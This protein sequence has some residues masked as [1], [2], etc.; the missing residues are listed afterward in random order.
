MS[1]DA[2]DVDYVREVV[3]E[4]S[5]IVLDATKAYLVES[6]LGP[7]ARQVGAR[8]LTDLVAMLRSDRTGRLR[9]L[10]VDAMTTNETTF[11]RDVGLWSAL[12]HRILPELIA[13]RAPERRLTVWSAACSSGQEPYSLAMLLLDRFPHVVAGFEVRIVATDLSAEMLGRAAAGRF[14]QLEVNRGLP[15]PLL[16]KHFVRD[17]AHWQISERVRS[18]VEFRALN[19]IGPWPLLPPVDL[20]FLRN[21]LIYFDQPTKRAI[22]GQCRRLLRPD[23]HLVLGTAETTLAI[24]DSYHRSVTDGAT[25]YRPF[26]HAS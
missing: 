11:F 20:L 10:V 5:A 25:T 22:L 9:E 2:T 1:L 19:L 4:R 16:V 26:A 14:T 23:G 3:R 18:L 15:A 13:R 12:E 6:R 24:D 7:V 8:D 21:V 17:G